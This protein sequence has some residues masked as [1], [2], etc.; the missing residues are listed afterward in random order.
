MIREACLYLA[1]PRDAG[2]ALRVVAG[3]PVAFRALVSA[4]RAGC[5][6]VGVPGALRGS[7][8]E[9]AIAA[10]PSAR[11]ATFWLD[12]DAARPQG[13][14]LLAPAA[15]LVAF[16]AIARVLES[17]TTTLLA[18]SRDS[19]A[20]L[21]GASPRLVERLWS[22][23]A[24]GAPLA[25]ALSRGLKDEPVAVTCTGAP[26]VRVTT[27][28]AAHA[29]EARLY[30]NL[31]SSNDTLLDR[32][33]HRRLSRPLTHLAVRWGLTPNQI[34]VASLL[35][36]GAAA[37][38]FWLTTPA[39]ALVGLLLY[40][41][42]VVLDHT[43]G[44]VARLTLAESRLGEWLDVLIDTIVHVLVVLAMGA[45]TGA[46]GRHDGVILGILAALGFIASSALTKTSPRPVAGDRV[47][48]VLSYL[49]TRD[50]F[51][52]MLIAFIAALAL[53]PASLPALM[54]AVALGAHSYWLGRAVHRLAG[55]PS[56]RR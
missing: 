32:S 20:P 12:P 37:W 15:A 53:W 47:G 48:V 31:G 45:T 44:E 49:G 13:A 46:L 10:T 26:Y 54:V 17:P 40:L 5:T 36:G 28:A 38:C 1:T 19:G 43:D 11:A 14:V 41:A 7:A 8:V 42:S 22:D 2:A 51:Y 52:A 27:D 55:R 33:V 18:E 50:G 25:D 35:V 30:G 9:D 34:S 24:G 21:V 23:I 39:T 4:M 56:C 3:R 16:P 6:R 29:A